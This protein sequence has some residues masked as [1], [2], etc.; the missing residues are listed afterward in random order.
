MWGEGAPG[1]GGLGGWAA[2]VLRVHVNVWVA[3][4]GLGWAWQCWV[5]PWVTGW[6]WGVVGASGGGVIWWVAFWGALVVFWRPADG[7]GG[8]VW[9]AEQVSGLLGHARHANG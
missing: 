6:P 3:L 4:G 5:A 7:D 2:E 8:R 9:G 1:P